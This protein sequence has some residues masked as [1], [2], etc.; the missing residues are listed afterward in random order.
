[1]EYTITTAP[2]NVFKG[3]TTFGQ[4]LSEWPPLT[5]TFR[6]LMQHRDRP[7]ALLGGVTGSTIGVVRNLPA[8]PAAFTTAINTGMFSFSFVNASASWNPHFYNLLPTSLAGFTAGS[9]FSYVMRA[10]SRASVRAG[11]TLSLGCTTLQFVFNEVELLRIRAVLRSELRERARLVDE[12]M[13]SVLSERPSTPAPTTSPAVPA[14][15]ATP[16]STT[17]VSVHQ[18]S[19]DRN[20]YYAQ[21]PNSS[22]TRDPKDGNLCRVI[23]SPVQFGLDITT[24]LPLYIKKGGGPPG[25]LWW[26][27][28][29]T[30]VSAAPARGVHVPIRCHVQALWHLLYFSRQSNEAT[31]F[32]RFSLLSFVIIPFNSPAI[33]NYIPVNLTGSYWSFQTTLARWSP[34]KKLDQEEYER[35]LMVK[36]QQLPPDTGRDDD[37]RSERQLLEEKIARARE[38]R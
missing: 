5:L 1:M 14:T 11:V 30:V 9:F 10:T 23:R 21:Y 37:V 24:L 18:T 22:T 38:R 20:D 13:A 32:P 29:H 27:Y 17:S 6:K 31:A 19:P 4:S 3:T 8:L 34:V 35:L 26:V 2:W 28:Q 12:E 15:P 7:T 36:L 16:S 33:W 25:R